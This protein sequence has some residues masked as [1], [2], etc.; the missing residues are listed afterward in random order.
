M[1]NATDVVIW[2]ADVDE[3][4]LDRVL[5]HDLPLEL[6]KL[7]RL[8]LTRMGLAKIGSVQDRGFRVF[9]DAKIIEIPDK[10]IEVA[11]LHLEFRPWML[12]VMA[13]ICST[14]EMTHDDPKKVDALK[15]FADECH[16]V[17]TRPCAVT[18]LTSKTAYTVF[19]EFGRSPEEQV[20][21]YADL[22]AEAGFTDMVC[23]PKEALLIRSDRTF[24]GLELNCPGIRL[25]GSN[26][27][28]QAR[29][30][31]PFAAIAAGVN[32]VVI[33]RDLTNGDLCEN[34]AKVDANLNPTG[35]VK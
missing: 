16:K 11:K 19:D 32:R 18:V 33:G 23:S 8:G 21:F 20:L 3:A 22:L 12:N 5:V 6:I 14:G 27:D 10:V 30:D 1:T 29:V 26:A 7:D 35:G 31:T 34:F 9:A 24:D 15:R 2:S 28:D 17:G 25:P 4:T 13:G